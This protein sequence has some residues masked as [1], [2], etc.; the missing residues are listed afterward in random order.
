[1]IFWFLFAAVPVI[2]FAIT[3]VNLFSWRRGG[4]SMAALAGVGVAIPARNEGHN[5]A[6]AIESCLNL[7]PNH[8]GLIH[9]VLVYDDG[10]TDDT[11]D[12]VLRLA[13][14]GS[15]VR[16]I[17]GVELPPGWVGKPHACHR[18]YLA[19]RADALLFMDADVRLE[20]GALERL[21]DLLD[22]SGARVVTAVPA[23]IMG[24][25]F[26]RM[27][28]PLLLV[29]Y[30]SW[31]PLFLVGVGKNPRTV[32]ANGQLLFI[33]R[34]DLGTL[35]GFE[36]V[37]G[38]IVDDVAF[39]RSAKVRGFKVLFADGFEL[40]RCRMYR[41]AREVWRGFSKNLF[42]GIGDSLGAW[43]GVS[44]LYFVAFVLPYIGLVV[45]WLSEEELIF[46]A[47]CVGVFANL[48]LRTVLAIRHRHPL[49]QVLLHPVSVLALLAIAFN[50][51]VWARRDGIE[52]AGRKYSSRR[53]R[54]PSS[55]TS[56]EQSA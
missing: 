40:G 34:A 14:K 3:L 21:S 43:A 19:A 13:A 23:Q 31:L 20:V 9:E 39:C 10:S 8:E 44:L 52:W 46:T 1:M 32:A 41:N 7:D 26:E 42:E 2:A 38:E 33:R 35:G 50:S 29:T 18:L 17:P 49:G 25:F 51:M 30:T 28:L 6:A 11:R 12:E 16:L 5:I 37:K 22:K 4:T 24:S 56:R 45:G 36:G 27:I 48:G 15:R 55:L 53:K 54:I 47:S